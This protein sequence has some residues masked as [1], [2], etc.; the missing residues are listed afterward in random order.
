MQAPLIPCE[1][2]EYLDEAGPGAGRL[3]A[4]LCHCPYDQWEPA[5]PAMRVTYPA[6]GPLCLADGRAAGFQ[7]VR[8]ALFHKWRQ[9]S[10]D[11]GL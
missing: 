6:D 7:L 4:V 11:R 8:D 3:V 2:H 10:A 1:Y 5:L 9:T